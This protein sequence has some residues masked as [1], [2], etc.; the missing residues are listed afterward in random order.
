[1]RHLLVNAD[2]AVQQVVP[3]KRKF[4]SHSDESIAIL[5]IL[6]LWHFFSRIRGQVSWIKLYYPH[7]SLKNSECRTCGLI[8]HLYLLPQ[9][10]I[11]WMNFFINL[12]FPLLLLLFLNISIYREVQ[13]DFTTEIEALFGD[14]MLNFTPI[15][16]SISM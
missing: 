14:V 9:V 4:Y 5:L 10:Y 16:L 11:N 2:G 1:M 8:F 13:W 12:L 3:R 7:T 15:S 6:L